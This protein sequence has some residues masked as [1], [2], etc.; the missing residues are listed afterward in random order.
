[1]PSIHRLNLIA[2]V[3]LT[4]AGIA[5]ADSQPLPAPQP[6]SASAQARAQA[7]M[8]EFGTRLRTVLQEQLQAQGP[9]PAIDVCHVQAPRIAAEVM[10]THGVRLGRTSERVRNPANAPTEWQTQLLNEFADKV[11]G[12]EAPEAQ[13]AKQHDNLPDGVALRVMRGIPVEAPC[14]VCHGTTIAPEVAAS[15]LTY[16]PEDA[17]TGYSV[18]E[19]RGA[20]WVEVLQQATP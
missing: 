12:G 17:A 20:I 11:T 13:L 14:T 10:Q 4:T 6:D 3:L 8:S 19:L 15:L 7:A 1:M 16:Y 2:V 18:G 9:L 5:W